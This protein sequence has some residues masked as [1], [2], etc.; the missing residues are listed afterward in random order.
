MNQALINLNRVNTNLEEARRQRNI[1]YQQWRLFPH[2]ITWATRMEALART[3]QLEQ[4]FNVFMRRYVQ[5]LRQAVQ[6]YGLGHR[7]HIGNHISRINRHA[8]HQIV[9]STKNKRTMTAFR[10]LHKLPKNVSGKIMKKVH[11]ENNP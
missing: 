5:M 10:A 6:N 7:Y 4:Q 1:A 2:P 3:Y 9:K 11:G 8:I